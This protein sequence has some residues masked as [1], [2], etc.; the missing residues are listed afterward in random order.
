MNDILYQIY[1]CTY[2]TDFKSTQDMKQASKAREPFE[3]QIE[4]ALGIRFLNDYLNANSEYAYWENWQHFH[5]GFHFAL[6]LIL[7]G[8]TPV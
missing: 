5:N 8:L 2:S 3:D 1:T 4:A 6:S 7:E